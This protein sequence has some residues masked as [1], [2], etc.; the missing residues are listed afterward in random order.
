[1]PFAPDQEPPLPALPPKLGDALLQVLFDDAARRDQAF[2][3]L[4][5]AH[6]EHAPALAAHR[7]RHE[8]MEHDAPADDLAAAVGNIAG[9]R[10]LGL[11]GEGGMGTVYRAEQQEPH[12][13]VAMKVIKQGMDSKMVLA[14]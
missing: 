14:R 5:A 9:Y 12:R 10:L 4:V 6:P 8:R 11:L 7:R 2:A 1:M 3:A 13:S